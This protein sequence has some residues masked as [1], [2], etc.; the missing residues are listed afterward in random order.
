[1]PAAV[2]LIA[3]DETA[4][5]PIAGSTAP[6]GYLRAKLRLDDR[7]ASALS[8]ELRR[9]GVG[10]AGWTGIRSSARIAL[11][12]ALV[13]SAELEL[14]LPD[15]D[16]GLGRVWPWALVALGWTGGP[17]NAALAV[18]ASASPADRRRLDALVQLGRTWSVR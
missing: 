6:E 4:A 8:A 17:W 10:D 5:L 1:G 11:P 3:M 2:P 15:R 9:D 7:G 14:V 13:T 12:H 18:E 16:R